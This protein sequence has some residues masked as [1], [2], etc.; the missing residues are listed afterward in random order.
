MTDDGERQI[1][2]AYGNGGFRVSGNRIDG[3]I[4]ILPG[5]TIEW[6]PSSIDA[7][8]ADDFAAIMDAASDIEILLVGGGAAMAQLPPA[9][10]AELREAGIVVDAMDTG[11]AC[12]TY[13]VLSAEDRRVAAALIAVD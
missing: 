11:A 7:A 6:A 10:A 5:R 12:R 9:I 3:S 4:V 2:Q 8:T 13:S 1:L